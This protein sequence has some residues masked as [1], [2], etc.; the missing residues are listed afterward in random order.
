MALSGGVD[1]AVA[2]CL[3]KEQGYDC[4]G[5]FMRV[6]APGETTTHVDATT[7]GEF[8]RA[9]LP[10]AARRTLKHGCCSA[11]DAADARAIAGR[12]GI[13]FY[14]LNFEADFARIIDYFVDEYAQART[15]NPCV[16]CNIQLKFGKLLRYADLVEAAFVATGHYARIVTDGDRPALARSY[17]AAKDQTYVLFGMQR[18]ALG[19]CLF[20]LGEIADKAMVRQL[21]G[22]LGLRVADKPE[23]QE[24]CFVPDQDYKRLVQLRRPETQRAGEIRASSGEMLGRHSGVV[25][26]TIGQRRG[27]GLAAGEP[28]YVTRLD[29]ATNTVEVGPRAALEAPALTARGVNW[30]VDPPVVAEPLD[31]EVKIRHTHVPAAATLLHNANGSVG[32]QFSQPQIAVTPGQAVV[33]YRPDG[34]V[35]GGGWI[36]PPVR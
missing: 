9:P 32:V 20:P 4:I 7:D 14:A 15:P 28:L 34:I 30:L 1:S 11:E 19:R 2:A 21:A 26:F 18:A 8:C 31:C 17:N 29:A 27:L 33:F 24:I 3:L 22:K 12:L 35:L 23:S 5:V 36:E 25:N 6:G 16:Q 10:L 13:P